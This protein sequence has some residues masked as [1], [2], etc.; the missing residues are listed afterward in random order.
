MSTLSAIII[1]KNEEH[2]IRRCLESIRWADEIVVVDS[3]S[4]DDTVTICRE[5]TDRVFVR[6]FDTF[7]AQKNAALDRRSEER[8][9]GKECRL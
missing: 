2:R 5:F 3:E 8:R 7:S 4:T 6:A 1:T 9:V